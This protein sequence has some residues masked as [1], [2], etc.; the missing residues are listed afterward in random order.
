L[1][2]LTSITFPNESW[3]SFI[4]ASCSLLGSLSIR[5]IILSGPEPQRTILEKRLLQILKGKKIYLIRGSMYRAI[6]KQEGVT[7]VDIASAEELSKAI[8]HS[9]VIISRAGYSSI[10]DYWD[11]CHRVILIPTPGQWEQENL[12]ETPL[13]SNKFKVLMQD[14]LLADDFA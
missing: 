12:A 9:E 3:I 6:E 11:I 8:Q 14:K 10:M 13:V 2:V 5:S 1:T 7:C 4:E